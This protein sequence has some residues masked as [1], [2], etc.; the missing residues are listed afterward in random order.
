MIA[1]ITG[2]IIKSRSLGDM[3]YWLAPIREL[4]SSFGVSENNWDVYRGDSF[5]IELDYP[6]EA[7]LL[8]LSIKSTIK[9]IRVK[10]Q[11]QRKSIV[12]VRLS[13]GIGEGA[14]KKEKLGARMGKA[15]IYSGEGFEALKKIPVNMVIRSEWSDFDQDFNLLLKFALILMDDWTI[16]SS[17][18]IQILLHNPNIKQDDIARQLHI[19]QQSVSGRI[20]RAHA[21][22]I[23]ELEQHFRLKLK[24]YLQ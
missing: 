14:S 17:E 11:K 12:D 19:E 20:Q 10:S 18:I 2:D 22:E 1:V 5:Q 7:L 6:I 16:S 3:Q 15:H 23:M 9:S 8:A 24:T 13:I 21:Y 4:L